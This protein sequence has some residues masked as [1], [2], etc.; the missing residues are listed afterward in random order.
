[1]GNCWSKAS[2][3]AGACQTVISMLHYT[4]ADARCCSPIYTLIK[5]SA[6]SISHCS[7]SDIH[8]NTPCVISKLIVFDSCKLQLVLI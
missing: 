3:E 4:C 1:M 5:V 2:G 8:A 6:D 7:Y